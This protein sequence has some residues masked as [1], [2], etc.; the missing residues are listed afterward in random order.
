MGLNKKQI[1]NL[2]KNI[3]GIKRTDNQYELAVLYTMSDYFINPTYEDNYPTVNIEA[4]ACGTKVI[5]YDTGGCRE[6]IDTEKGYI[7]PVGNVEKIA[8]KINK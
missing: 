7:I 1:R 8:E 6:Q 4:I 3:I 5:C 2:P